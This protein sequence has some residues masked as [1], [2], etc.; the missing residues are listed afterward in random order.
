M[1]A[2]TFKS[3]PWTL[4]V[5]PTHQVYGNANGALEFLGYFYAETQEELGFAMEVFDMEYF[6]THERILAVEVDHTVVRTPP[7]E[8]FQPHL[9][10]TLLKKAA[11]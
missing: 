10:Y 6:L 2:C 4:R 1:S 8:T 9:L 3:E 11:C 7:S 5:Q